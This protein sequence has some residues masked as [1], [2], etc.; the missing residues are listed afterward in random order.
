MAVMPP[1]SQLINAVPG[2]TAYAKVNLIAKPQAFAYCIP[3]N[4]MPI[5]QD[6]LLSVGGSA[7]LAERAEDQRSRNPRSQG[8]GKVL[9]E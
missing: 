8:F 6:I 3:A 4:Y 9:D 5:N 7:A 1:I 2:E